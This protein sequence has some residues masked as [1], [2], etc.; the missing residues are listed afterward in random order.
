MAVLHEMV[1]EGSS[2]EGKPEQKPEWQEGTN[3][4]RNSEFSKEEKDLMFLAMIN[5]NRRKLSW[6]KKKISFYYLMPASEDMT[7]RADSTA[8]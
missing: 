6:K 1:G 3:H 2:E 7:S 5:C 8:S 4:D